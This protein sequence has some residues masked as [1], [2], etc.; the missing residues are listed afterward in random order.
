MFEEMRVAAS[1]RP[2]NLYTSFAVRSV[3]RGWRFDGRQHDAAEFYAAITPD[4]GPLQPVPWQARVGGLVE[5]PEVCLSC[6]VRNLSRV[7][8]LTSVEDLL[9][10]CACDWSPSDGAAECLARSC[11]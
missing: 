6:Q 11:F 9:A 7:Q 2:L 3:A 4:Q 1:Q 8:M 5:A 10:S